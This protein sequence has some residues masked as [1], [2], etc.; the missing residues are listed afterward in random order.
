MAPQSAGSDFVTHFFIKAFSGFRNSSFTAVAYAGRYVQGWIE[1]ISWTV[2][3]R[4]E[5]VLL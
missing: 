2:H 4:Y 3:V 5:E 1:K